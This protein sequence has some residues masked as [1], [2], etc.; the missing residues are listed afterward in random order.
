[1]MNTIHTDKGIS[2]TLVL[3]AL[4]LRVTAIFTIESWINVLTIIM[5]IL[6]I[7]YH[8][9][10]INERVVALIKRLRDRK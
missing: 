5:L 8:M 9:L 4:V 6:A 7:S 3:T 10:G 2:I 1:M